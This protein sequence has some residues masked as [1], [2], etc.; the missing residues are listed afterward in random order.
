VSAGP[1]IGSHVPVAGGLVRRA[2]P[3]ARE[4]GAEAIQVFASNPR[5]WAVPLPDPAQDAA[6]R[7]AC[8]ESG[9][10]VLIHAPY[11]VNLGSPD[12][13]TARRSVD[14]LRWTLQRAAQIGAGAVVVHAGSALVGRAGWSREQGLQQAGA[15]IRGL[16]ADGEGG[17]AAEQAVRLLIEPTA[18]AG[19]A[20]ASDL[21]SIAQYLEAVDDERV[22]ICLDTC[23]L[24][25]AGHDLS[26]RD[27][28]AAVLAD[29]AAAVGMARLGAVHVNDSR[30]PVGSRRDRHAP[31]GAGTIGA[32]AFAA[33][34]SSGLPPGVPVLTESTDDDHAADIAVLKAHRFAA[35]RAGVRT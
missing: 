31:I 2:L 16:L 28:F 30:D 4:I 14:A 34:F 6:F 7:A 35:G 1:L 15:A 5:G 13:L 23:H 33:L 29:F 32:D 18:G 20:L 19:G 26:T 11:L 21:P 12:P 9:L 24:H 10:S 17:P 25:A 8:A 3:H 27:L 22:G